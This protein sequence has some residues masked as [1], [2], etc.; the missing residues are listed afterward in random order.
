MGLALARMLG[1]ITYLSPEAMREKFDA[2]RMQPRD[3]ATEFERKFSVGSYLA[4]QGDRFVERF[5]ANSY[6]TLSLAMDLFDLGATPEALRESLSRATCRW[7]VASF[8][9]DWLFPPAQSREIVNTLA[10]LGK[11][12]SYCN[13]ASTCGHDAFLLSDNLDM[14]GG[15]MSALLAGLSAPAA[16]PECA[17]D[18]VYVDRSPESVFHC[19]RLDYDRIVDLVAKGASVLDLGCGR[20]A[21]LRR[22][23]SAGAGRLVGVELEEKSV[24]NSVGS[25][26]DVI[27]ADLNNGLDA[28]ADG[29]FDYVVLSHTLQ[30]ARDVER[31]LYE[32][33]RVGR[34]CIVS[35]PNFG[36]YKLR[37]MLADEGK[38]PESPGLLRF[39][40][41]DTPNLRFFTI[42]DFDEFCAQRGI[43]VHKRIALDTEARRE[44]SDDPNLN[45]DMAIF[46]IS[47]PGEK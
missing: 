32:M 33:A 34:R 44:V 1:H 35:F 3:V 29:Q 14:Y 42:R 17:D 4:Y 16:G 5:D 18:D 19:H 23:R 25:G 47:R 45:A 41:Y 22:L 31:L 37:R 8:T 30:T 27:Q 2:D 38:S 24:L 20:G 21:L 15:L 6:V 40:W 26:F 9:S 43:K 46:V 7:L 12:V 11:Q 39:K 13:I 36:Y 10:R 28:F